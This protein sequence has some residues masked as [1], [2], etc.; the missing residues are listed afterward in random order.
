[1][2]PQDELIHWL[3]LLRVSNGHN[4]RR[5]Y[6]YSGDADFLLQHGRWYAPR[7]FPKK[8]RRQAK[9]CAM[10]KMCFRNSVIF[11]G[12]HRWRYVEGF[13]T[14]SIEGVAFVS[15]HHAWNVD[16][17]NNLLDCTWLNTGVAYFGVEF[18]IAQARRAAQQGTS[19]LD[20]WK[21]RWPLL[22][23]PFSELPTSF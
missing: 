1:M 17:N 20:D 16:E 9:C 8:F 10:E 22:R 13:A 5:G 6:H 15:V 21:R 7:D 2:T 3:E 19:L 18:P 12:M 23:Y 4:K 11:C 14:P